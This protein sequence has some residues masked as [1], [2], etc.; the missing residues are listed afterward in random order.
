M[1]YLSPAAALILGYDPD[2][3]V[4]ENA[5][6]YIHP[7]DVAARAE[8]FVETVENPRIDARGFLVL[9]TCLWVRY[10]STAARGPCSTIRAWRVSA[11][12]THGRRCKPVGVRSI[13]L[14]Q[15]P[16]AWAADQAS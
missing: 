13:L 7:A 4:G 12:P 10:S 16:G 6:E 8:K 1:T 15:L 2:E 11:R 5:V 3:V 14:N 9:Q